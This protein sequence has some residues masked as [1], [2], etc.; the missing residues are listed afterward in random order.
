MTDF[1]RRQLLQRPGR[2]GRPLP[3]LRL[4]AGAGTG[5]QEPHY[6]VFMVTGHP[7]AMEVYGDPATFPE[8]SRH[9]ATFSSCNAVSGPFVKF[10]EP[11]VGDDI[12][13]VIVALSSRAPLQRPAPVVR[14]ARPH[15]APS[16]ADAA[17][18]AEAAQGERGRSCG[19]SPTSSS[20]G[21]PATAPS[22]SSAPTPSRSPCTVVAD[23]EG[24][25]ESDH[26]LFRER[27]STVHRGDRAQAARVPLRHGS[28]TY[29]EDRRRS[30]ATTS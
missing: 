12:T 17:H 21:S 27:L 7:E 24:V 16:P 18:H 15:G 3:L 14:S 25:P 1:D 4:G 26:S 10:S 19:G 22:S 11:V 6:G 8:T 30:P 23:L 13:D 20:T 5:W 9:P 28:A 2:P 29:I